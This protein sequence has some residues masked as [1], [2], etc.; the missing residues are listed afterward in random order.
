ML[1]FI[2][3]KSTEMRILHKKNRT[4]SDLFIFILP[5]VYFCYSV[6][7]NIFK[8][9]F[10]YIFLKNS[11][12]LSFHW[13]KQFFS[14][15]PLAKRFIE[16]IPNYLINNNDKIFVCI[17]ITKCFIGGRLQRCNECV[18]IL[19]RYGFFALTWIHKMNKL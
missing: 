5:N 8:K 17:P 13:S 9:S 7:E 2:L 10:F 12:C 14:L 6:F 3:K 19:F 18:D 11:N 16:G 4:F 15:R 1:S